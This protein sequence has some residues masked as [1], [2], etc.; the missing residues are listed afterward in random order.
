MRKQASLTIGVVLLA[1]GV[2]G[3]SGDIPL[4]S[5]TKTMQTVERV[6]VDRAWELAQAGQALLVC[7]YDDDTCRSILFEGALLKSDFEK[8]IAWMDP[9]QTVVFYCA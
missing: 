5:D 4:A 6:S 8:R 9:D 2:I 1:A 3:L 7:A